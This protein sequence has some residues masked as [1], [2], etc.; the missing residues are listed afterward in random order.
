M[1]CTKSIYLQNVNNL[2]KGIFLNKFTVVNFGGLTFSQRW[3]MFV[4]VHSFA[5]KSSLLKKSHFC[6]EQLL[7]CVDG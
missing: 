5:P 1:S 6:F 3:T 2:T 4:K 7:F